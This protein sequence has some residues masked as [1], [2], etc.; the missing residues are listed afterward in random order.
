MKQITEIA[1]RSGS[2]L[3]LDGLGVVAIAIMTGVMLHLPVLV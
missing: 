1:Q 2:N 3:L